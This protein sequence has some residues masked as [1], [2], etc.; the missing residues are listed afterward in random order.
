MA[1]PSYKSPG[2]KQFG[3]NEEVFN[4]VQDSD[5]GPTFS[6]YRVFNSHI[7]NPALRE[8]WSSSSVR[9]LAIRFGLVA[10]EHHAALVAEFQDYQLTPDDVLDRDGKED[11]CW[12]SALSTFNASYDNTV[13]AYSNV[14]SEWVFSMCRK[15]DTDTRSQLG[16][17]NMHAILSCKISMDELC[18][19]FQPDSNLL[20]SVK[21][22]TWNY[23]KDHQ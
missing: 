19:A 18:Y 15:I 11:I 16:N 8:L 21:S 2:S 9:E 13:I 23:A 4:K 12:W 20:K 14:D 7:P 1:K 22:A 17:N 10:D 6:Y 5:K 3:E